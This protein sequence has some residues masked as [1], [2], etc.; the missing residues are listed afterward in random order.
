MD[1]RFAGKLVHV[2]GLGSWG[3]GRAVARVLWNRGAE[4]TVSDV[5]SAAEL[6]SEI[7]GLSDTDV[8]I[9]T[10]DRAYSGIEEAELVVVSPGVPLDAPPLLRVRS[11]GI[12]T[13]SEI[14]VAFWIAPCPIIAVT[15]TK[16]KSTTTALIGDLLADAGMNTLVGGNIGRPLI[17]LAERAGPD[18]MLVAEVSSFQLEATQ[19]FRPQVAVLLNLFADHLDRHASMEAYRAAK[20]RIFAAQQAEDFAVVNRDDPEAWEM[21]NL[22]PA[23]LMPYSLVEPQPQGADIAEGWLRVGGKRICPVEAVRLRGKHNLGNVL[24][25]LAAARA[26][27]AGLGRAEETLGRFEGLEHRLEVVGAVGGVM[28]VND[29]QATTPQA[30]AAAVNAFPGRVILIAGGRA[31]V[32]DFSVLAGAL[33][34]TRASLIV[35]GEAAEGIAAAAREAGVKEIAHARDLSE[36]VRIG[37]QRAR[38][39]DV[40][41]L[42]PA[43]ASF[44]MFE[45]MAERGRVFKQV[46]AELKADKRSD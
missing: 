6:A 19:R 14:E 10:G 35:I 11:R 4:V 2:I 9:Q 13:V 33:A 20:G 45:D 3:T 34:Q 12:P 21:R 23:K 40:V 36:A 37:C 5:K 39:G 28:F 7:E 18:D 29:S 16:G 1:D 30:A 27:G 15:G 38:P 31:K 44:D 46:V 25:A 22:T 26:A 41:L 17:S 8:V 24:A 32:H 42:S 43:C